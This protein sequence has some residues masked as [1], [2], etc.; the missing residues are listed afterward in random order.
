MAQSLHRV[1]LE[2][3]QKLQHSQESVR[4][5]LDEGELIE[6][7]PASYEHNRIRGRMEQWLREYP[8]ARGLGEVVAEMDF[9][10]SSDVVRTPD[11]AF[12]TVKQL[13]LIHPSDTLVQGAP[14]LAVE[15]IS[16]S[17]TASEIARKRNQYLI[18]GA[19]SV[20]IV[21]PDQREVEV[22][23]T[24]ERPL[25]LNEKDSLI[26]EHLFPKLSLSLAYVFSG[27]MK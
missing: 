10:L 18:A 1:T 11:V 16:P 4:Y 19:R 15:I 7:T 21:Y 26:D 25:I 6:V 24:G 5:E 22:F 17:N 20:W 27:S 2:E 13:Q 3:F 23:R 12:L 9:Q 14:A 8:E